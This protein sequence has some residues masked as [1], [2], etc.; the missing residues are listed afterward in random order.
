MVGV[1]SKDIEL[2]NNKC[3]IND[4]SMEDLVIVF[5]VLI[6]VLEEDII[7]LDDGF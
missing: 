2:W 3:K 4:I 7:F 1:W 6:V 5:I